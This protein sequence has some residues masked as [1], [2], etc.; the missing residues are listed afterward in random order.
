MC[1]LNFCS[2]TSIICYVIVSRKIAKIN[3]GTPFRYHYWLDEKTN[4]LYPLKSSALFHVMCFVF[5]LDDFLNPLSWIFVKNHLLRI[6]YRNL[7]GF[8]FWFQFLAIEQRGKL[9]CERNRHV[10]RLSISFWKLVKIWPNNPRWKR[11]SSLRVGY[12]Y[13]WI[14]TSHI[15]SWGA[16]AY[17]KKM[18]DENWCIVCSIRLFEVCSR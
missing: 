1:V 16:V 14:A 12:W 10:K 5:W 4:M 8:S 7:S 6:T 15:H 17:L 13:W 11:V 3:F 18:S 9:W 2:E